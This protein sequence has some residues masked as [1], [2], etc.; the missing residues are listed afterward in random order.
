MLDL[1]RSK[2]RRWPSGRSRLPRAACTHTLLI[3]PRA[4][5]KACWHSACPRFCR[6][7]L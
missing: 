1:P 4:P 7:Q 2:A 5:A 6:P 3:V